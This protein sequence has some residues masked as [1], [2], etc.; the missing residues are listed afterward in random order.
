MGF[1][2]GD[3]PINPGDPSGFFSGIIAAI[4]AALVWLY[5]ALISVIIFFWNLLVALLNVLVA[6][7]KTLGKFL[8]N[9][10]NNYIKKGIL[11]LASHI[12]KLRD[13][14]QR[15]LKPVVK[16]F[17]R[18]KKWYDDHILKQQLRLLQTI[19]KIRRF[20]GILRIFHIHW[21]DKLDKMLADVQN[22][23]ERNIAFV[24]GI[25]NQI[26]NTLALVMDPT[27]LIRRNVLGGTL[28]SNLGALKR[29][30]GF[31]YHGPLTAAETTHLDNNVG[32]YQATTA[33]SHIATL[34]SNGLTDY[35][36]SELSAAR[37]GISGITG[38]PTGL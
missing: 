22:R 18:L 28:L 37:A 13:W 24:R 5:N 34:A 4:Y 1:D 19:Q 35:D 30:F 8:L 17:Q 21:A 12:Q 11:W 20:L 25:L 38:I 14:L 32:R 16:F 9:V 29:I 31:F 3:G 23:I 26:I 6:V 10:W 27:L 7:F 2:V 36:K 15:V 33:D